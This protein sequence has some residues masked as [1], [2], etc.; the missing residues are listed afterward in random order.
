MISVGTVIF[1]GS[2]TGSFEQCRVGAGRHGIVER[3]DGLGK[4]RSRGARRCRM[5]AVEHRVMKALLIGRRLILRN[6]AASSCVRRAWVN[7]PVHTMASSARRST[8]SGGVG[9]QRGAQRPTR[10][11]RP[12]RTIAAA[13]FLDVWRGGKSS[14]PN[15]IGALLSRSR[16]SGRSLHVDAP[17]VVALMRE[18]LHRGRMRAARHMQVEGRLRGHRGAVHEQ[19]SAAVLAGSAR[20]C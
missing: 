6:S 7:L 9:K 18:I 4:L 12:E 15:A 10:C 20:T 19:D 2:T 1:S 17:R 16:W 8:S 14:A 5:I 11:R 13:Q 3:H